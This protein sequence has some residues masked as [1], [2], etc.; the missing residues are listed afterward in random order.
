MN[1]AITRTAIVGCLSLWLG[2]A[3]QQ[4]EKAEEVHI[5]ESKTEKEEDSKRYLGNRNKHDDTEI[6]PYQ[7]I[8]F[9]KEEKKK[10]KP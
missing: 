3:V 2:L 7:R 1:K 6:Y 10:Q 8:V 5:S 9:I 4:L